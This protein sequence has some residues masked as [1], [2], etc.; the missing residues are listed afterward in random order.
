MAGVPAGLAAGVRVGEHIS[1][2]VIARAFPPDRVQQVLAETGKARER[3][4]DL[5]AQLMVYHVGAMALYMSAAPARR[6]AA[7]WRACVGCEGP[8][9]SRPRAG[10]A[11]HRRAAGGARCRCAGCMSGLCSRWRRT[12]PRERGIGRGGWCAWTGPAWMWP[13]RPRTA[14]GCRA[15][16]CWRTGPI[17]PWSTRARRTPEREGLAPRGQ[18]RAGACGRMPASRHGRRRAAVSAGGHDPGRGAGA[19]CGLGRAPPRA[20][21]DRGRAGRAEN[22]AP[23]NTGRAAQQDRGPR[24]NRFAIS[25]GAPGVLGPAAGAFRRARAHARS[26]CGPTR[27]R[28]ACCSCMPCAWCAASCRC[29]RLFPPRNRLALHEDVLDET[30]EE[31][32]ASSRSRQ[33][34]RGVKR[35]MSSYPLRPRTPQPTTRI[36]PTAAIRIAT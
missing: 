15:Q 26:G 3:E 30:L 23:R 8:T 16:R 27:T 6:C 10:A 25:L 33:L 18:W 2:G 5:P 13:T 35:K 4:R 9:R 32:V 12:P 21:G 20:L 22:A 19:G 1:L 34:P 31:R 24:A 11:S 14:C 28:I 29:L 36:N 7:C 17:C